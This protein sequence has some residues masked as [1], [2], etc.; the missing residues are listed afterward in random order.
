M[1]LSR[2]LKNFE[3]VIP[4]G[5]RE[6]RVL[7]PVRFVGVRNLSLLDIL[8]EEGFFA[9]VGMTAKRILSSLLG[10]GALAPTSSRLAIIGLGRPWASA[11]GAKRPRGNAL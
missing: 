4:N 8:I 11:Q 5:L 3:F 9:S 7:R 6:A 1:L 2:L 10:V